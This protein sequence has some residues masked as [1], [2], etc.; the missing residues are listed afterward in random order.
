MDAVR[1]GIREAKAAGWNDED[2]LAFISNRPTPEQLH[3]LKAA[4]SATDNARPAK[5]MT[6]AIQHEINAINNEE[7]HE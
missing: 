2:I 5:A 6:N 1:K 7:T 3:E 4:T